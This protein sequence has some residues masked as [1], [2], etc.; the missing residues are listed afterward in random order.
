MQRE[1]YGHE[2]TRK[3][4]GYA[5][6]RSWALEVRAGAGSRGG[7]NEEGRQSGMQTG[8]VDGEG[9]EKEAVLSEGAKERRVDGR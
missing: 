3:T 8:R 4:R 6:R 7:S 5:A 1:L 9:R 2:L